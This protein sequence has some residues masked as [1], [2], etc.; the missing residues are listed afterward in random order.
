M[1]SL[2]LADIAC[3]RNVTC[4]DLLNLSLAAKTGGFNRRGEALSIVNAPDRNTDASTGRSSGNEGRSTCC[5]DWRK[6]RAACVGKT[7]AGVLVIPTS[8]GEYG[9]AVSG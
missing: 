1:L 5:A 3:R 9:V 6:E 4:N 2:Q 8:G 7:A